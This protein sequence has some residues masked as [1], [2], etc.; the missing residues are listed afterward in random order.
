MLK[1]VI[2]IGTDF[3]ADFLSV[4]EGD[5][6]TFIR[7]CEKIIQNR[8]NYWNP[9]E[10][11]VIHINTT[12]SHHSVEGNCINSR[13][14]SFWSIGDTL[15]VT[16]YHP[17]IYQPSTAIF[18][19]S[20]KGYEEKTAVNYIKRRK[21]EEY[22]TYDSNYGEK[23]CNYK[24]INDGLIIYY[25]KNTLSRDEASIMFF[26]KYET[27]HEAILV[28]FSKDKNWNISDAYGVSSTEMQQ[29]LDG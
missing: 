7:N 8:I 4:L 27:R 29:V 13:D 14:F 28:R 11:F 17:N 6:P 15:E 23:H 1:T 21:R 25:S 9:K 24:P 10:L 18:L 3:K 12:F 19:R 16:R 22:S 2:R 20:Y 5:D 26:S